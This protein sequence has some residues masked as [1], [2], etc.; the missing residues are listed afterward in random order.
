MG[1]RLTLDERDALALF[2]QPGAYTCAC[3]TDACPVLPCDNEREDLFTTVER[4]I[5]ARLADPDAAL[6]AGLAE[7]GA[8]G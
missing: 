6:R 7:W 2:E 4:I 1:V 8:E 3:E 5:A